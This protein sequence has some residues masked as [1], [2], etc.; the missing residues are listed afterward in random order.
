MQVLQ[1]TSVDAYVE[2]L[3]TKAEESD[4][5]FKELLINVTN[6][7]RDPESFEELN[8]SVIT[9]MLTDRPSDHKFRVWVA[10]CSTGEEVYTFA[11]LIKEQLE[12]LKNPPE[13]QIIATD[14]DEHALNLARKGG[15]FGS[16]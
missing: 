7:F 5:L 14:I 9:K 11:I 2:R 15:L 6:F 12:R 10:G 4:S 13:V 3:N 8:N 16:D 1:L